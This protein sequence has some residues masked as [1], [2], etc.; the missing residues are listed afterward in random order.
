MAMSPV[1]TIVGAGKAML[2]PLGSDM[3]VEVP[4]QRRARQ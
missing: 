3:V 2:V 1:S 4:W